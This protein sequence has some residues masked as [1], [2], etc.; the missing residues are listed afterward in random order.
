MLKNITETFSRLIGRQTSDGFI[1]QAILSHQPT[2]EAFSQDKLERYNV[3]FKKVLA[4]YK[5][6]L[7]IA[8]DM[9]HKANE[10]AAYS[11]LGDIFI[12]LGDFKKAIEY[13][14]LH[15]SF[16]KELK[17]KT[18]EGVAY[19]R[20][21]TAFLQL[22]DLKQAMDYFNLSLN[23]AKDLG[24]KAEEGRAYSNLGGALESLGDFKQ[25][26][27]FYNLALCIA[28]ECGDKVLEKDLCINLGN[29]F[30]ILDDFKKALDYHISALSISKDLASISGQSFAY[31][32][33]GNAFR[34]L[35]DFKKAL[36][37]CNLSL[38][39]AIHLGDKAGQAN[40]Y[41]NLGNTVQCLGDCKIAIEYYHVSLRI[42]KHLGY[43]AGEREAYGGLGT[44]FY[45]LGEFKKALE[46][47]NLALSIAQQLGDRSAEGKAY[48]G[49]GAVLNGLGDVKEAVKYHQLAHSI[50][51]QLG[52]K[53]NEAGEC[54]SLG[55]IF[56]SLGELRKA[57]E[58][59]NLHLRISKDLGDKAG[60]GFAYGNLGTV[61]D[62]LGDFNKAIEYHNRHLESAKSLGDKDGEGV[63]YGGLGLA[64]YS[65]GD[66]KKALYYHNLRL[67][68]AKDLGDKEREGIAYGNLG[69]AFLKLGDFQTAIE[70][71]EL[72]LSIA[73]DIGHKDGIGHAYGELGNAF[74]CLGDSKTALRYHSLHLNI[75]KD[76]GDKTQEGEAYNGIGRS[77]EGLGLLSEALEHYQSSV[78]VFNEMRSLLQSKDKWKIG[79]RNE[80]NFPYTSLWRVLVKQGKTVEALLAA[81]E[82]RAQALAD[83]LASK[84]DFQASQV[85]GNGEIQERDVEMFS[86]ISTCTVFL[87]VNEIQNKINAWVLSKG[88]PVFHW[89]KKLDHHGTSNF[90]SLVQS[91]YDSHGVRAHVRCEDRS[92]DALRGGYKISEGSFEQSSQSQLSNGDPLVALYNNIIGPIADLIQGDELII[93]PDGP[94]WLAP[95]A[96]LVGPRFKFL[97]ESFRIRLIPSLTSLKM[98]ADC[99]SEYHSKSGALL[100]GDPCVADIICDNGERMKQL[101]FA[102][103]EVQM[104][105]QILKVIPLTGKQATKDEV[106]K[107]LSSIALVHIAAH[108]STETGE[109]A[110]SPNPNR[111][112]RAPSE[113]DFL[114]RIADV[115]NVKLR[116]RLVVLSCCHSGQGEIKAEG[117]VGVARAFMGA[118]ARSVLVSLWAIDDEATLEFMKSFYHY[119]VDGRSASES[120]NQA[121]KSLRESDKYSDVKYWAPFVLIGD[122][123]TLPLC[124]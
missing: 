123:V 73:E 121:M 64:S 44:A 108:G 75:A 114:L 8:Q 2:T 53:F 42:S 85:W 101:P 106:L 124:E 38:F 119:L 18:D 58:Y 91:A 43:K 47:H 98:I 17:D 56:T 120:L 86:C 33:L 41:F 21:G 63:A 51:K 60:E 110:L 27:Y 23:L 65:L 70:Y 104:I 72:R 82:G 66:F 32:G 61:F 29:A 96:A 69:S 25:A 68:I 79:F 5:Q 24:H 71:Y 19:S 57:V 22:N 15:L 30:Q 76:L 3:D 9:K 54:L 92:L 31:G 116:A 87:A 7:R 45:R 74:Q 118:G 78:R 16:A 20:L 62:N 103:Q 59:H 40:A 49:L 115:M 80:W 109:I 95:Y 94:L 100:V 26:V 113:E 36:D 6:R 14:T 88:K 122:D 111:P 13:H 39:F 55:N 112:S 10:Q 84:F 89:Q 35:G 52:N 83:L 105:G 102:R 81:E 93:V 34:G 48:G 97:C 117:V 46:H 67:G 37:C 12:V 90:D 11:D 107:R 77:L 50:F 4:Y 28:K 1:F 99:P